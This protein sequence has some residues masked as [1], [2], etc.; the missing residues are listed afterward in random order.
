MSERARSWARRRPELASD[1]GKRLLHVPVKRLERTPGS[2]LA[3]HAH[4]LDPGGKALAAGPVRLTEP[5]ARAVAK[6]RA[7]DLTAYRKSD[8]PGPVPPAPEH[9]QR[10]LLDAFSPLHHSSELSIPPEPFAPGKPHERPTAWTSRHRYTAI[11]LRPFARRRLRTLRPALV[12][13]RTRNPWVR[14]RFRRLG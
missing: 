10:R 3:C 5:P 9:D 6:N 7:A 12:L 8:L 13:I 11:R 1:E 2:G 4:E 14:L